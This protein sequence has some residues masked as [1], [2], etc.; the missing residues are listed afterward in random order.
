[1]DPDAALKEL[2]ELAAEF[3]EEERIWDGTDGLLEH[4]EKAERAAELLVALDEWLSGG[5]AL[6]DDWSR[7]VVWSVAEWGQYES[8]PYSLTLWSSKEAATRHAMA[9]IS[10]GMSVFVHGCELDSGSSVLAA[11][12]G[13]VPELQGPKVIVVGSCGACRFIK[14]DHRGW[15][16]GECRHE[17]APADNQTK[18]LNNRPDWCPLKC[19]DVL[20]VA[21]KGS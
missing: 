11:P 17:D 7:K 5:C 12:A 2:R 13:T 8:G 20:L 1:M 6:P 9:N 10:T 15:S 19:R 18:T 16:Q 3:N 21:E 4:K 14:E